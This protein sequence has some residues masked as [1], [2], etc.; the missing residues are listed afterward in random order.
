MTGAANYEVIGTNAFFNVEVKPRRLKDVF[1]SAKDSERL[2]E[3]FVFYNPVIPRMITDRN[4]TGLSTDLVSQCLAQQMNEHP[5][6]IQD[7]ETPVFRFSETILLNPEDKCFPRMLYAAPRPVWSLLPAHFLI[8]DLSI[9][10]FYLVVPVSLTWDGERTLLFSDDVPFFGFNAYGNRDTWY[11]SSEKTPRLTQ[12]PPIREFVEIA[13][14]LLNSTSKNLERSVEKES[15]VQAFDR[16]DARLAQMKQKKIQDTISQ[17]LKESQLDA[18]RRNEAL[19]L[20]RHYRAV[21]PDY[22]S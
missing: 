11:Y 1:L 17:P 13:E 6:V 18:R 2:Q 16:I 7:L 21:F 19:E 8:Q 3:E 15:S 10:L 14:R 22:A 20:I 9:R 12:S 4:K 5:V